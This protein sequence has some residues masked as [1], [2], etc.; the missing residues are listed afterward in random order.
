MYLSFSENT[1]IENNIFYTTAQ[2]ILAYSTLSQP[3]LS[4]IYN[5]IYCQAGARSLIVDWNGSSY[6]G[7]AS[8]ALGSN[9]NP[10]TIFINPQFILANIT[11]PNFHLAPSSSS[12]NTGNPTFIPSG[13]E[14][15]IDGEWRANGIVDCGADEYYT[16]TGIIVNTSTNQYFFYS[17]PFSMQTTLQVDKLFKEATLTICNVYR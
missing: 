6:L 9:T 15:D 13:S 8:F 3:T 16:T 7:Y 1:V 17:N 4:F 14:V 12:I 2:N 11:N 5:T 10:N